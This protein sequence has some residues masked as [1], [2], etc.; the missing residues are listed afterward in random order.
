MEPES[1]EV[2]EDKMSLFALHS[3]IKDVQERLARVEMATIYKV[4]F[5]TY[6]ARYFI[7][8]LVAAIATF[9]HFI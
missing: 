8:Y 4:G 5:W 2:Q 6:S 7:K 3:R 1:E 9:R